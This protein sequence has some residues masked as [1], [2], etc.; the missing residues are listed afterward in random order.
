MPGFFYRW[1]EEE[2]CSECVAPELDPYPCLRLLEGPF[3][4]G[5]DEKGCFVRSSR[6]ATRPCGKK[7]A[8]LW[9]RRGV[10]RNFFLVL[11]GVR[12]S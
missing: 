5:V 4:P 12:R 2:D 6:N 10:F 9:G 11:V 8:F 1:E 3:L 7:R